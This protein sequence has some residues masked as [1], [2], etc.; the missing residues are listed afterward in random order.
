MIKNVQVGF[1]RLKFKISRVQVSA[2]ASNYTSHN[3]NF[4]QGN[5]EENEGECTEISDSLESIIYST[6]LL[7]LFESFLV[8]FVMN[9]ACMNSIVIT[10]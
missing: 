3:R 5:K 6:F 2:L 1:R 9:H 7:L 10:H 4:S 8:H